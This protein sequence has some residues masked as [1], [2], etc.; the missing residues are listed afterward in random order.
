MKI[1]YLKRGKLWI[2]R[3]YLPNPVTGQKQDYKSK[4]FPTKKEAQTDAEAMLKNYLNGSLALPTKMT[5][6]ELCEEWIR[7]KRNELH[8]RSSVYYLEDQRKALNNYF[9]KVLIK[10][11]SPI[12]VQNYYS[13]LKEQDRPLSSGTINNRAKALKSVLK[14]G[15]QMRL[16]N[17][18]PA[19]GIK[20]PKTHKKQINPWTKEEFGSFY[21]EIK[22]HRLFAFYRLSAFTGARRGELLALRRS[23]IDFVKQEITISK[24]RNRYKREIIEQNLTKS[25]L[26][27]TISIDAETCQILKDH[28]KQMTQE[29]STSPFPLLVSDYLFVQEDG[30]PID[31]STPSN[32]FYKTWK[33]LGL[34]SQRLHDLRHFHA[35]EL[36]R[37]GANILE[38]RDRLGH[39]SIEITLG[40]YGH[41]RPEDRSEIAEN[42]AKVLNLK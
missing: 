28:I 32:L 23:D 1:Q 30:S 21:A 5:F 14:F 36:I 35:T 11:I 29:A 27:R 20:P 16:L 37:S 39:S 40:I 33:R 7:A 25:D 8:K 22:K 42:F 9:G 34:R 15:V 19:E 41:L 10:D 4:G 26:P 18:N 38:V 24:T 13:S 3:A 31:P 17:N 6:E 2:W 12:L